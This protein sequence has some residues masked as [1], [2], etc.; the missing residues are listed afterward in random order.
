MLMN[1][2][3]LAILT[4]CGFCVA[5]KKLPRKIRRFIQKHSLLADAIALLLT[6]MLLGGTLTALVAAAVVGL[7]TSALLYIANNPQ[8]FR[9]LEDIAEVIKEK[10]ALL[11]QLAKDLGEDYRIKKQKELEG[12]PVIKTA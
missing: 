7:L 11:K 12:M 9:I 2:F 1:A 3:T 10:V 5:Y 8:D 6:Y 4:T